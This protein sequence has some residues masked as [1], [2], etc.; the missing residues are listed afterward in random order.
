MLMLR[1]S[2]N[3][4]NGQLPEKISSNLT[5]IE[6]SNNNF[7]GE[8]PASVSSWNN[9]KELKASNNLFVGTIPQELTSLPFLA[10]LL[11]DWNQLSGQIPSN[12][13]SWTSLSSLN[14]SHNQLHGEIPAGLGFL[15]IM[16]ELDLSENDLSGQIPVEV[17]KLRLTSLN[18]SSNLLT[19]KLP[20]PFENGAF[21][22]SF[23]NNHGL[24]TDNPSL[25]LQTCR[26]TPR[27]T[28]KI[29]FQFI[30]VVTSIVF[31]VLVAALLFSL[32]LIKNFREKKRGLDTTWKLTS[33]QRLSFTESTILS[34]L[35]ENNT[36][37]SGGSGKVYRVAINR[38]GESVAVK[39]IW[40]NKKL[41]HHLEKQFNSEVEI[42]GTIRHPNI[43]KLMCSIS[44]EKSK[45]LVYPYFGN[46]SLDQ[47]L[48]GKERS[49]SGSA[50]V[51]HVV[52]DWPKRLQIAVGAARGLCY[53][54]H[55]CSPPIIHG[56]IKSS[57]IL[58]DSEFNAKIVDFGLA[59][60]L[61]KDDELNTISDVAGSFGYI[62]PEYTQTKRVNKKTDVYSFGVVLLELVTGK[63]ANKGGEYTNLAEWVRQ[64]IQEGYPIADVLDANIKDTCYLDEIIAV[65]KL[66]IICTETLPWTRPSMMRVMQILRRC[67]PMP[68]FAEMLQM[69]WFL[70][71][72]LKNPEGERELEGEDDGLGSIV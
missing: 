26:S 68:A 8:I 40:T 19:G 36:I 54:H 13:I 20:S 50:S 67:S 49:P 58:L 4:F 47:W 46:G 7:S 18:L 69:K 48:H 14:L 63:E 2:D 66:G 33:F 65:F 71:L 56:D 43:V 1:L 3:F 70:F 64:H 42:L 32:Y 37:G 16:T 21:K 15:P 29:S 35:T 39:R 12:I 62:A 44:S 51:H 45:L 41:D 10:T 5:L 30:I 25:G 6:I 57:N 55:K 9:L 24:C 34:S 52:L 17:G 23:L 11:L 72:F 38:S 60:I 22:N 61:I 59:Q 27:N 53:M 28:S 31:V